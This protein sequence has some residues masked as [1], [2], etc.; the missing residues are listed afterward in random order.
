MTD[1]ACCVTVF[2]D[3]VTFIS[4]FLTSWVLHRYLGDN[5]NWKP[6]YQFFGGRCTLFP[7]RPRSSH[8]ADRQDTTT[9]IHN[10]SPWRCHI[11]PHK[12]PP[13][14]HHVE[15]FP[16]ISVQKSFVQTL[17]II[18]FCAA[19][20]AAFYVSRS[21][22]CSTDWEFGGMERVA[23]CIVLRILSKCPA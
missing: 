1:V 23:G 10:G 8:G 3:L 9:P 2:I 22:K 6:L 12:G 16:N 5:W 18:F 14:V 15:K 11:S 17:G 21:S 7:S 19:E 4:G 13:I 20:N